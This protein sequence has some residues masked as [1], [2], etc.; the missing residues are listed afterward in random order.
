MTKKY[1]FIALLLLCLCNS[2][3]AQTQLEMNE[4]AD[5]NYKKADAELNKVYKQ[6]IAILDQNE[7]PLLIQAEKDWVRFRDSHCKFDASQYEGG[8][9][10]PLVYS[11]CLEELTRKRIAEIKASI[12]ERDK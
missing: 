7:K 3:F 2:S 11:T 8:S 10:K 12:K 4:T 1:Y 5:T 6:L 9:I